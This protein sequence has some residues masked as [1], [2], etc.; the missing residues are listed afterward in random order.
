MSVKSFLACATLVVVTH[1][2]SA[3][4]SRSIR[5]WTHVSG[6]SSVEAQFIEVDEQGRA[7][8]KRSDGNLLMVPLP[9]LSLPDRQHIEA[10]K[11]NQ[12]A[13][14]TTSR[15]VRPATLRESP[16]PSMAQQRQ[17][18]QWVKSSGGKVTHD[19]RAIVGVEL[20]EC[21]VL[22][23][24]R[25]LP[26]LETLSAVPNGSQ[27]RI[28]AYD[29]KPLE[30]LTELNTLRLHRAWRCSDLT[31]LA[32]LRNLE[33][34]DL[35]GANVGDLAPLETLTNL[36]TLNLSGS[37][38]RDLTPLAKL[39]S[40]RE[41]DLYQN[42][43]YGRDLLPLAKLAKLESLNVA[44]TDVDDISPLKDLTNLKTLDLTDLHHIETLRPLANLTNLE[45]LR[46][47]GTK[48]KDLSPLARLTN[49]RTLDLEYTGVTELG[50]LADVTNL[51]QLRLNGTEVEDLGPLAGMQ[52]LR[53]L[54]LSGT[55]VTDL[56]PLRGLKNMKVLDLNSL[57][58]VWDLDPLGGMT[59]MQHL[60]LMYTSVT[61]L[62][63]LHKMTKLAWLESYPSEVRHEE[64][65]KLRKLLP[66]CRAE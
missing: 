15:P 8:L 45:E 58:E 31:P 29:L 46:L 14:R 54:L 24:L 43:I 33:T 63:P 41:L 49:L 44:E 7:V 27:D 50:P 37:D 12:A 9:I 34:I 21:S 30:N 51:E 5:K 11:R 39:V 17:V 40:L 36:K 1:A 25:R 16:D 4:P 26:N 53:V 28:A 22:S 19:G 3:E 56:E 13:S 48:V 47:S 55:K 38:V 64:I 18:L 61:D 65:K 66:N 52:K 35:R 59:Q 23:P 2:S 42:D 57:E 32:N 6:K 20:S 10:L 60:I 62:S